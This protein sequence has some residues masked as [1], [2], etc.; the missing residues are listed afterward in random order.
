MTEQ[1]YRKIKLTSGYDDKILMSNILKTL[2]I[3]SLCL[4][5]LAGSEICYLK[6]LEKQVRTKPL[7]AHED[8]FHE[9]IKKLKKMNDEVRKKKFN[10]SHE[11]INYRK[12]V[13]DVKDEITKYLVNAGA[14]GK[15]QG[16]FLKLEMQY[17]GIISFLDDIEAQKNILL[18]FKTLE[19]SYPLNKTTDQTKLIELRNMYTEL[20]EKTFLKLENE[21]SDQYINMQKSINNKIRKIEEK[22]IIKVEAP[23]SS[24]LNSPNIDEIINKGFENGDIYYENVEPGS[25]GAKLFSFHDSGHVVVFKSSVE[26]ELDFAHRSRSAVE[27]NFSSGRNYITERH[28]IVAGTLINRE[29]AVGKLSNLLN[30]KVV[31]VTK[32]ITL[33]SG[34]KGSIQEFKE[35]YINASKNI[36]YLN[37]KRSIFNKNIEEVFISPNQND[38][39]EMAILDLISGNLD[40]SYGNW[41]VDKN[42]N[43]AAIDNGLAFPMEAGKSVHFDSSWDTDMFASS[44]S[45][46]E[47][48]VG[49]IKNLDISLIRKEMK[50]NNI[51]DEA[52]DLMEERIKLL[53]QYINSHDDV[54]IRDLAEIIDKH[55]QG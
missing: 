10:N 38:L 12:R 23:R 37:K 27:K 16:K 3:F 30:F 15:E 47:E 50:S 41:M 20:K 17:E 55:M 33:Q 32:E 34:V 43:I 9:I 51:E 25:F 22:I 26:E 2:L 53:K 46:S 35:G 8:H 21:T 7:M 24:I 42:G 36:H 6:E 52:L 14:A 39:H 54:N 18:D 45:L 4:P 19:A 49:V 13:H 11:L 29:V 1:F 5:A 31:P 28:P 44:I 48:H 40:R